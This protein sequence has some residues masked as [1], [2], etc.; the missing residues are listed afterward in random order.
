MAAGKLLVS[1]AGGIC[2]DMLGA[3]HKL[4][5]PHILAD[6]GTIHE[7]VVTLFSQIFRGD[8]R[9]SMPVIPAE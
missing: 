4:T 6:N 3:P 1:E 2:C 5:G 9:H 7:E 8:Y